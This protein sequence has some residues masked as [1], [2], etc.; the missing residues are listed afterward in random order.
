[1]PVTRT[2]MLST[3]ALKLLLDKAMG[4]LVNRSCVC[5]LAVANVVPRVGAE[6]GATVDV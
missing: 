6:P 2:V 3:L 4:A 5:F 1:M